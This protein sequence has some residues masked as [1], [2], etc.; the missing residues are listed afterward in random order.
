MIS[1]IVPIY[2]A[3]T[4]LKRCIDSIL[5]QTYEDFELILINDGSR[6]RSLEICEEAAAADR[7]VKITTIENGGVANARNLGL[8]KASGE[9]I[10]FIDADDRIEPDCLGLLHEALVLSKADISICGTIDVY[11]DRERRTMEESGKVEVIDVKD[12]KWIGPYSHTV[13]WGA[14]YRREVL[15]GLRFDR[16]LYVGEDTYFFSLALKNSRRLAYVKKCLYYYYMYDE[17]ESHGRF[18]EKKMTIVDAWKKIVD[19][20]DELSCDAAYA[21]TIMDLISAYRKNDDFRKKYYKCTADEYRRYF[22]QLFVFCRREKDYITLLRS[23]LL[24]VVF[25]FHL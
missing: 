6:D 5:G 13:V 14:L 4:K 19:L 17:S 15:E 11:N 20:Y 7:R 18:N 10:T 16:S 25:R 23:C 8:S 24:Y 21:M 3:E 22:H 12:F 9:F 1:V 2:N